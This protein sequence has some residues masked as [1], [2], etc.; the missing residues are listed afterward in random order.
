MSLNTLF[1]QLK[2]T[3]DE[4]KTSKAMPPIEQWNPPY[5][6]EI[7][8]EIK[9][10]GDWYYGGSIIKRL[11][12]V[13]LFASVL[14]KEHDGKNDQYFLITPVEKVKISVEE[15]PFLITQWRWLDDEKSIMEVETNLEDRFVLNQNHHFTLTKD[16]SIYINVRRNLLA[17]VHR[18]VYYQWAELADETAVN[19]KKI[20][21][22]NSADITTALYFY[23]SQKKF[24]LGYY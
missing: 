13:K 23:S 7:D 12:L 10:N 19:S 22:K 8:I 21:M 15:V 4:D 16:G 3:I 6:G 5:C 17:K 1:E 24:T 18:N 2:P 14:L 11:S 20:V 9:D